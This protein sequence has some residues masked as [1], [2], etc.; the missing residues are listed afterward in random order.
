MKSK[1]FDCN[2]CIKQQIPG[3]AIGTKSV[4]PYACIFMDNLEST[5]LESENTKPWVWMKYIDDILKV[6]SEKEV[7]SCYLYTE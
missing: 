3:T 1:Y 4:P 7:G 5:F 6:K 2:S